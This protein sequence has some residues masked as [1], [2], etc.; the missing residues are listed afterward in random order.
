MPTIFPLVVVPPKDVT[1]S[2]DKSWQMDVPEN[3]V[4]SRTSDG[5]RNNEAFSIPPMRSTTQPSTSPSHFNDETTLVSFFYDDDRR[6]TM[7]KED[8]SHVERS[9]RSGSCAIGV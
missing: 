3:L 8:N 4:P 7:R 5:K 1:K 2:G 9:S 6:P